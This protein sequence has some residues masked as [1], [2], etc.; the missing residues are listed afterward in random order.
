MKHTT[1]MLITLFVIL[2]VLACTPFASQTP[3][4]TPRT[5]VSPT[6]P[7]VQTVTTAVLVTPEVIPPST[8]PEPL[9]AA[10][11]RL[12][13]GDTVKLDVIS[14]KSQTEGW[15][16]SGSSVLIT[17]D[18]GKTWKEATPPE[19]LTS[20]AD[21]KAYGAFLDSKTAWII[22]GENE[23]ILPE[24]SVWRTS[25][26]GSTWTRSAPL[27]HQVFSEHVW[28]EFAVLDA[29]NL[30]VMVRGVYAGAGIHYS[31]ELFRSTD[32]GQTW[33]SLDG[34]ISDD[35][36]GMVFF[37][38]EFGVRTLETTGAYYFGPPTFDL[39][40][41]GGATW[42]SYELPPPPDQPDL[43][44]TQYPYCETYQPVLLSDHS[45][46]ML[47]GCV[48]EHYPPE[49]FTS[50]IYSSEDAGRTWSMTHLPET[51]M[52][53][54]YQMLYLGNDEVLLLGRNI[55]HSSS[56]G[57]DWQFIQKVN[58]DAQFSFIDARNGWATG[59]GE[60]AALAQTTEG[61][62]SWSLIVPKVKP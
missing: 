61:G 42:D 58:W 18:G 19:E 29:D 28:A 22:F 4:P 10:A 13:A 11:P 6:A 59:T 7:G 52:A 41:D 5:S 62:L 31:H 2:M 32:G 60:E 34:E 24:A 53:S 39:T 47:M 9:P 27:F 16:V 21:A 23:Q 57:R 43:F 49:Q 33:T 12:R 48:D 8:P 46:R 36:T 50:Y 40:S 17:R 1:R 55:Y 45:I 35:Y 25:D 56:D 14:M 38:T 44:D 51:V 26:S 30:W 3:V 54:L 15:G 20:P 37:N